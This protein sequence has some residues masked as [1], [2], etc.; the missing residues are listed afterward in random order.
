MRK[1]CGCCCKYMFSISCCI[2]SKVLDPFLCI[3][4]SRLFLVW[5]E[6]HA[7][8]VCT[9]LTKPYL[10]VHD[11]FRNLRNVTTIIY[12]TRV[13]QEYRRYFIMCHWKRKL[14]SIVSVFCIGSLLGD[15]E[16]SLLVTTA[17]NTWL[18]FPS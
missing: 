15:H 2:L 16:L 18:S 17:A 12:F 4:Y 3:C 14:A 8:R 6:L 1:D 7:V 13:K 10:A 11:S 5:G 9:S